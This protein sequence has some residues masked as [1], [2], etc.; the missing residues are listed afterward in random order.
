MKKQRSANPMTYEKYM[1]VME[2]DI[3]DRV[4][5][6]TAGYDY[7]S[8]RERDVKNALNKDTMTI[9]DFG[10]FL[11]PAA[12]SLLEEMA[13]RARSETRKHFGNTVS[14]YTPL[15]IS[16]YCC[17]HCTYCGFNCENKITRGR[18]TFDEIEKELRAISETDLKE[19]LL[20]TGESR[21]YSDVEYIGEA[22]KLAAK[23]FTTIGIEIYPLNTDE[24]E[25]LH[26]CGADFVSVYQET[27]DTVQ[28]EKYHISGPKRVY[29]YRF[30][31]Q[32]RA[33]KGGMRGVGFGALL[34]L[35]DFRKDAFAAG[36]HAYHLQKNYP[37]AEISFSVPRIRSFKNH[38]EHS[39]FGLN[40]VR[41]RQ[42]LQIILAFRIFMPFASITVSTRERAGFR[43]HIAGLAANKLS[44]GVKV[45]IGG[46]S[47]DKKGD[48]QF[49]ISDARD[50]TGIH[51]M[52]LSKGLQP[53][54]TDY[55]RV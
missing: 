47:A 54:Y 55:I 17:N 42:L 3:M 27:Y 1:E 33:L 29:P 40:T 7:H 48:E 39:E 43:D 19:I 46:H 30:H 28:Y 32:E 51:E 25:Y 6:Q 11:S 5:K 2:S 12:D 10:A 22:V 31:A 8:F 24:Y 18:L 35:G 49:E 45:G 26:R 38:R 53:V 4:L 21:K 9:H 36:I 44:A 37:H 15:Y 52:I 23:Y 41:E 14:L 20:L 16:N 50:V 13:E 34:G